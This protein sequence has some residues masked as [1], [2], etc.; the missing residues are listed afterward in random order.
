MK[1][2]STRGG[3]E[4]VAFQDAV[5]MGLAD[6][7]GLLIPESIPDARTR[8]AGWRGLSY[9][10]LAFEVL[11]LFADDIPA[12]DLKDLVGR[13]YGRAFQPEPAPTVRLG[14][15]HVLELWHGPTLSFK[16][17]A[18]QFLGNLFEHILGR[19]GGGLNILGATSGDTGS[20]AIHGVRG[21]RGIHIFIMHPRGR[22]SPIQE[23]QMTAVL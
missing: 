18:L 12:E 21:R 4:A 11:R 7:G 17:V 8:L 16:D 22:V 23:R 15:L 14:D 5:L 3:V 9:A 1:Y 6:D 20:A 2:I 13:T 19:R 10:D